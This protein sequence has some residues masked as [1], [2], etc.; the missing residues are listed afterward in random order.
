MGRKRSPGLRLRSGIWHI[1]KRVNGVQLCESCK[2]SSLAEAEAYLAKRVEE[3]RK[4]TQFGV[5]PRRKWRQAATYYLETN[6]H[7]A[8]IADDAT[9]LEQLDSYIGNLWLDQ[10]HDAT[11]K[12]FVDAR[13]KAGRK[14]KT[15]NLALGVVRRILN[16]ATRS[17]RDE[18]GLTWLETAPLITMLPLND[19]AQPYPLD[20]DEERRLFQMLPSHLADMSLYKVNTGAREQEVCHLRWEWEIPIPELSTSVFLV[21]AWVNNGDDIVGLVKNRKDRLHALNDVALSVI[22]KIRTERPTYHLER[23]KSK[24][25]GK[26]N[27]AHGVVFTYRGY[28]VGKMHNNGWKTAWRKAGLPT[29]PELKKGVHNLKHTFGRR[30]RAAGVPRETR[31]ALLGH[32]DGNITTHYSAA[33]IGELIEGANAPLKAKTGKSPALTLIKLRAAGETVSGKSSAVKFER[34]K[35]ATE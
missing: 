17:W 8:S 33:E 2:T 21:P 26:C 22:D 11:L 28:Q 29:G 9:H 25:G 3:V 16:L 1:E 19:A 31:T 15:V 13:K 10:V 27:C 24:S 20:W 7:K 6:M 5:R 32:W 23:C 34:K 18:Y 12:P 4:A 14:S 35:T 30:L